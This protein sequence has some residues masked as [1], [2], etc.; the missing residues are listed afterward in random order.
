MRILYFI[1]M[2]GSQ[3]L[4]QE[5]HRELLHEFQARGHDVAVFALA[6]R[7]QNVARDQPTLEENIP[8]F[9][10]RVDRGTLDRALNLLGKPIFVYNRF[11]SGLSAYSK[12][13]ARHRDFDLA[14]I[15]LAYP[16]GAMAALTS[17]RSRQRFVV[18]IGGGD[19]LASQEANYGYARYRIVRALVRFTFTRAS[20]VRAVSPHAADLAMRL[21]C[22]REKIMIVPRNI[23]RNSFS[24]PNLAPAEFREQARVRVLARHTLEDA[25]LIVS[26]G[27]LLPIKGF[28]YLIR[29]LALLKSNGAR[30]RLLL[31]GP[32]R[33]NYGEHLR[34]L[35][36]RC[37]VDEHLV[38]VGAVNKNEMRDYLAAADVVAVPSIEEGGNK[39]V[40]EAAAVG[41]PFVATALAGTT[42]YAAGWD[43][44]V[45]VPPRDVEALARGLTQL[46]QDPARR[47]QMGEHGRALAQN[48]STELIAA[49]LL[50][51]YEGLLAGKNLPEELRQMPTPLRQPTR[52]EANL[53]AS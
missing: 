50:E 7:E 6:G 31:V 9:R 4:G 29:A 42:D 3:F 26:A 13:V 53:P 2:Y 23:S 10:A 22:P 16:M 39:M 34:E 20:L 33:G 49:R 18:H 28:D 21:G 36:W 14:H 5:I 44:G 30:A 47:R 15:E 46:L 19:L 45:I 8:V 11:L 35:A 1:A 32:E 48:F 24:P 37:G 40:I 27:R 25:P 43:C 51:A 41:T 38:F 52:T 12:H 17:L